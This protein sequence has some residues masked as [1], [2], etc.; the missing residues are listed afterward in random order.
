MRRTTHK[1]ARTASFSAA[2]LRFARPEFPHRGGGK[3]SEIELQ[4]SRF[5]FKKCYDCQHCLFSTSP[6]GKAESVVGF[7]EGPYRDQRRHYSYAV[8]CFHQIDPAWLLCAGR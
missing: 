3:D 6:F 5:L 7:E 2:S 1:L 4:N 8:G